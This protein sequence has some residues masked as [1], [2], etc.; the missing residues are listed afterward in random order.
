MSVGMFGCQ[1]IIY[2][3]VPEEVDFSHEAIRTLALLTTTVFIS[4]RG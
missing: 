4:K 3:W 2:P 1:T